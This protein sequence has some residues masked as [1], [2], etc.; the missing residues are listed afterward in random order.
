M[1][2]N[3]WYPLWRMIELLNNEDKNKIQVYAHDEKAKVDYLYSNR[4]YDIDKD[5]T[6]SMMFLKIS[7]N[8]KS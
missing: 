2:V 8:L 6:K 5:F 3:S 4:I 7:K 1:T